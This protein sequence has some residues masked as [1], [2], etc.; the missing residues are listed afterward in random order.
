MKNNDYKNLNAQE[1]AHRIIAREEEYLT[2]DFDSLSFEDKCRYA[3]DHSPVMHVGIAP[4]DAR[5]AELLDSL[6]PELLRRAEQEDGFALYVLGSIHADGSAPATEEERRF[7]ERA[8]RAGYLPA[9][10]DLVS[11]F[12]SRKDKDARLQAL[13]EHLVPLLN[14]LSAEREQGDSLLD[15]TR[16]LLA[17]YENATDVK[18]V[19]YLKSREHAAKRALDGSH[20]AV[21]GLTHLPLLWKHPLLDTV[22]EDELAF[23]T[24][25][26]FLVH[27]HFYT[28]G[29]H[30]LANVI[31]TKL[32]NGRGCDPDDE[33]L[34][35]I[36]EEILRRRAK[37]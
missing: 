6:R 11:R 21:S 29:A 30:H 8:I 31:D 5:R 37:A 20:S 12:Y 3:M 32:K 10:L 33:A 23:W 1:V 27:W 28:H 17:D 7:L 36:H 26:D 14:R 25:V 18:A 35:R 15:C 2:T 22:S 13:E 34:L 4:K 24:T 16:S 9:T 19:F